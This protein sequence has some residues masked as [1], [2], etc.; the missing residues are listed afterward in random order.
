MEKWL[1]Q[2]IVDITN[3]KN[4]PVKPRKTA[5]NATKY[6]GEAKFK[7]TANCMKCGT[8]EKVCPAGNIKLS[9]DVVFDN[10]CETCFA[11]INL[12]PDHAIYSTVASPKR[13]QYRNPIISVGEI[14]NANNKNYN[15]EN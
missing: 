1:D 3:R 10:K 14:I 5:G 9:D 11:C 6:F 8:C 2:I 12:C 15:S 13:R 4:K 7:V